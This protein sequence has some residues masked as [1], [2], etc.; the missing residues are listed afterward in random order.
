[1][2][3]GKISGRGVTKPITVSVDNTGQAYLEILRDRGVKYFFGNAGTDFAPLIDGFA[4]F[5]AEGKEYP[6][7][8]LV[9]HE[10][11]AVS[12]A[13]GYAMITG[14]PQVVM[15][16]VNVGTAN[17]VTGVMNASRA[18][19][20]LIFTAGRTPITEGEVK[21]GRNLHI[22]WAQESFDQASMLREYVK[23]DYELRCFAQVEKVVD[24]ALSIALSEPKGPVYLSL[25]RE[26]LAEE[27]REFT[28]TPAG[29]RLYPKPGP[30][31]EAVRQAA[32]LLKDA[33]NPLVITSMAGKNPAAVGELVKLCEAFA[34]P[35]TIPMSNLYL[36]FPTDHPLHLGFDPMRFLPEADVILVIESDVPWFPIRSKPKP[37]ARVIQMGIDPLF[38]RYPMR[39]FPADVPLVCD[40]EAGLKALRE[41]LAPHRS[42]KRKIIQG[43]FQKLGRE[44][45]AQ[46]AAWKAA[47]EKVRKAYPIDMEWV[48]Y[49]VGRVRDSRTV[50][51]NEYDLRV[52]QV[53]INEPGSFFGSPMSSGLGWCFGAALG[54][55]LARPDSVPVICMGDGAY[56]FTGATACHFMAQKLPVVAVV[57]NNQCWNAVKGSVTDLYPQGWAV[58]QGHFS[59]C[60]L[61]PSPAY[62][63]IAEAFGGYGERVEDPDKIIPALKRAIKAVRQEKRQ[64]LLNVICKHP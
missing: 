60:D 22:H 11:T 21:G 6:K 4:R 25:P 52:H 24:R 20:P 28:Y 9:P 38:S 13:H 64:A 30:D 46:R 15:V 12:M 16:H 18:N 43:R 42:A 55:K 23:W 2:S 39:T 63:K 14:E 19:I 36:N 35:V 53:S 32:W 59:L 17:G 49:C 5:A 7:P 41:A 26:V 62:E 51:I 1:M 45:A 61:E 8:V 37:G 50:L 54:V 56:H 58:R 40:P 31:A 33:K 10:F 3:V 27:H 48:S 29:P 47:A 44:H 57:F 34:L